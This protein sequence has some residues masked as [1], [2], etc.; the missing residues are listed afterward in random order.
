[1][2]YGESNVFEMMGKR[3]KSSVWSPYDEEKAPTSSTY[4][5]ATSLLD[6]TSSI[7]A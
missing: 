5:S 3:R 4:T 7:T 1:M 2:G 6:R